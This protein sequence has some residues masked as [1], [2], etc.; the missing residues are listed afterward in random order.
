MIRKLNQADHDVVFSFL[1]QEPSLNL[2]IIG[3]I[4]AFGYEQDFQELWGDFDERGALRAVLLRFYDSYIPYAPGDFD[5][6]GLAEIMRSTSGPVTLSGKAELVE[7]FE[8]LLP[9]GAKRVMYFCECNQIT[10]PE[11]ENRYEIKLA[12]VDDVDRII[13]LRSR[14]TEF[15]TTPSSRTMLLK[16]LETNTGRTYYIEE[17]GRMVSAVSTTA[18]NTLS[19]MVVGVCTDAHYR[20]K[21]YASDIMKRIIQDYIRAGKTLCL[22]YDNPEAGR[23]YKRLG[24]SDIGMWMMYR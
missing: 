24:F 3:D 1:K 18:E 12:T 22:F 9:L 11:E 4:E 5:I 8:S 7:K 2:F 19:A 20:Q 21:G 17:D 16:A 6:D 13:E 15:V 23:I 10:F 14:I